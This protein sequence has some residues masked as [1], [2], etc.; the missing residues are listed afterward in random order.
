MYFCLFLSLWYIEPKADAVPRYKKHPLCNVAQSSTDTKF[1][2]SFFFF[3]NIRSI[4]NAKLVY[5]SVNIRDTITF[6]PW[7][8]L[9]WIFLGLM[10]KLQYFGHL[11]RRVNS[12]GKTLILGKI[13]R[14]RRSG[15]QRTRWLDGITNSMDMSVSKFWEMVKNR[16]AWHAA[17][18]GVAKSQTWLNNCL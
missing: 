17:G 12:S 2:A 10:L 16:A 11:M 15:Q 18:H 14:G 7:L 1:K 4:I 5:Y 8:I 13:D 9:S 6:T 3:L